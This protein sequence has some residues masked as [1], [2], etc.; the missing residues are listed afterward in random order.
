MGANPLDRPL[1]DQKR[2]IDPAWIAL[3]RRVEGVSHVA[4]AF[5]RKLWSVD[6]RD[7]AGPDDHPHDRRPQLE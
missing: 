7:A 1:R 4:N 3:D 6:D 2:N 5:F